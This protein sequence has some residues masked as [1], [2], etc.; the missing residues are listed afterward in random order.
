MAHVGIENI[1]PNDPAAYSSL[2]IHRLIN[3]AQQVVLVWVDDNDRDHLLS[4]YDV[5]N[6]EK[7]LRSLSQ[8]ETLSEDYHGYPSCAW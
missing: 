3:G 5:R 4:L 8:M 7:P 1:S 2:R 6:Q